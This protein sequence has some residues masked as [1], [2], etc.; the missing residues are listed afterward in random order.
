MK[1]LVTG[2]SGNVGSALVES[3][4]LRP[5]VDAIVG[6]T[7]R[8]PDWRPDGVEWRAADITTGDLASVFSGCDTVIHLAWAVQPARDPEGLWMT[9]VLG[10]QRVFEAAARAGV[11]SLVHASSVAAYSPAPPGTMVS[12]TWPT[13]GIPQLGY[14]WQ[15]AYVERLLDRFETETEMP[16]ARLRPALIFRRE[17]AHEIRRLFLGS[18]PT[19]LLGPWARRALELLPA[20]FQVV[21]SRDAADAFARAAATR[22]VG[23]FNIAADPPLGTRLSP[24]W[25]GPVAHHVAAAAWRSRVFAAEPGWVDLG[26]RAPLMDTTRARSE[27]GWVPLRSAHVTLDE[28]LDGLR[29]DARFPTPPL[30][31]DREADEPD[32]FGPMIDLT[33]A[34]QF[35]DSL[36]AAP[37]G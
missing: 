34:E 13:H 32:R 11:T 17:V 23:A 20:R 26:L 33:P 16:V 2:A 15:K 36:I 37:V 14:S 10:S 6:V 31:S 30:S 21:H 18:V 24:R 29:H 22:A 4:K 12:E 28:L 3:L 1:V 5:E 35:S 27:L 8:V 19:R 7:R 25:L 9:N